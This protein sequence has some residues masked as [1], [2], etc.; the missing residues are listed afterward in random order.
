MC[1]AELKFFRV[2]PENLANHVSHSL[3]CLKGGNLGGYIWD[4]YNKGY[5]GV[6]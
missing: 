4:Y 5:E 1:E 2:V 6:Y 3:N